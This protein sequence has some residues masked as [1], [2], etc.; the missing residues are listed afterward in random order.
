MKKLLSMILALAMVLALSTTVFAAD[1]QTSEIKGQQSTDV[2]ANYQAAGEPTFSDAKV[3]YVKVEW[4]Q[5]GTLKYSE[6]ST[7][8]KWNAEQNKYEVDDTVTT[9]A[10]WTVEN[11]KVTVTVTNQSNAKITASVS[12]TE[13][14]GFTVSGTF[15]KQSAEL[16]S[17]APQKPSAE[18][19]TGSNV[20]STITYTINS[21]TGTISANDT[22][23]ATLTVTLTHD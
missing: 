13:K 16:E 3:Y 9:G 10:G 6:G 1:L 20:Q 2:K 5:E 12:A 4:K 15:D 18:N 7:T 22:A 23:I 8:Y 11:A 14:G 19:L 21:V 17:A